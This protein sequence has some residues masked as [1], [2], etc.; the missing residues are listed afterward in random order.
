MAKYDAFGRPAA[1]GTRTRG[2]RPR[3]VLLAPVLAVLAVAAVGAL[4]AFAAG[5]RGVHHVAAR[6]A[7]R[8]P[9]V[10]PSVFAHDSLLVAANL[11][12][13]LRLA[14]EQG[15]GRLLSVTVSPRALDVIFAPRHGRS[16]T[17]IVTSEGDVS[18]GRQG[19]ESGR[20]FRA[21]R[22]DPAAPARF[23]P[24]AARRLHAPLGLFIAA[25]LELG[26]RGLR[27]SAAFDGSFFGREVYGT[28]DGTLT[29]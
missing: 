7:K 25:G 8:T 3:P 5:H 2:E 26:P 27:W 4:L 28:P 22:V 19:H 9:I 6:R 29:G 16:V 20:G 11:R 10:M 18:T 24:A 15:R 14:L 21:A 23:V 1:A 17:V 13:A 12:P